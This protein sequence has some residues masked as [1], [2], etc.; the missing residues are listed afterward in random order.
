MN[1]FIYTTTAGKCPHMS[2]KISGF[3]A[4]NFTQNG[5][6]MVNIPDFFHRKRGR[7][8]ILTCHLKNLVL[9]PQT[10]PKNVHMSHLKNKFESLCFAVLLNTVLLLGTRFTLLSHQHQL[11]HL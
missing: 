7:K 2:F 8:N 6:K 3:V 1:G 5:P 11:L 9:S 10:W 4:T